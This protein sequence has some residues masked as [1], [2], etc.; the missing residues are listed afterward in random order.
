M[1]IKMR[2]ALLHAINDDDD[3]V[4]HVYT[5]PIYIYIYILWQR[6]TIMFLKRTR[7]IRQKIAHQ[8]LY[9]RYAKN[10]WMKNILSVFHFLLLLLLFL[11]SYCSPLVLDPLGRRRST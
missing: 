7:A 5:I 8:S 3:D 1:H 4:F 10:M 11:Y 2:M 9:V 6:P